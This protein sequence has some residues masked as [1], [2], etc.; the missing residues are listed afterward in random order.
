MPSTRGQRLRA[1][2]EKKF[3]TIRQAA[4]ALRM[5][6]SSY[7][8]HER[9]ESIDGRDYGPDEATRYA[10][11]FDVSPEWL[12]TGRR[13]T[14]HEQL[15]DETAVSNRPKVPIIGYVGAGA[16]MHYYAVAQGHLDEIEPSR[17]FE[18]STVAVEIRGDSL[19]T[20]FNRWLVLYD[21]VRRPATD[22]LIGELCVVGVSD[23]RVVVKQ[24]LRAKTKGLFTLVSHAS[25]PMNNVAVDWAAKVKCILRP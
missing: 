10:R 20:T 2:R 19:G 13:Y 6:Y 1:A 8:A 9:A 21:Q 7:S 3:K 4:A 5:P 24:I 25:A 14:S 16:E 22:D 23:G 12:L 11:L 17:Q 15:L 18:S